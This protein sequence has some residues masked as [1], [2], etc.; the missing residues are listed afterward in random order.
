MGGACRSST[1]ADRSSLRPLRVQKS[2]G[3]SPLVGWRVK[4]AWPACRVGVAGVSPA[5]MRGCGV[6]ACVCV[7]LRVRVCVHRPLLLRCVRGGLGWSST[8]PR[9]FPITLG[10]RR[11]S[12]CA[13]VNA[14]VSSFFHCT[15]SGSLCNDS[16]HVSARAQQPGPRR[17]ADGPHLALQHELLPSFDAQQDALLVFDLRLL[18][19]H[20]LLHG[21]QVLL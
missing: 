8:P 9:L 3:A 7:R 17:G 15:N 4:W 10:A 21:Q 12:F 6:C 5:V 13:S 1:H 20:D 19:R 11:S 18:H 2:E 16:T 14:S